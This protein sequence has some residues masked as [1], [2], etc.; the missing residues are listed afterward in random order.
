MLVVRDSCPNN[1]Q[2]CSSGSFLLLS[3]YKIVTKGLVLRADPIQKQITLLVF[4][5]PPGK[6]IS[7]AKS[8]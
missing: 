7:A 5:L 3:K 8:S 6:Q 2:T 1:P 4:A